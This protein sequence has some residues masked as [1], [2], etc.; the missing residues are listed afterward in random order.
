MTGFE[1]NTVVDSNT[2]FN[3]AK[4]YI[5]T[6]PAFKVDTINQILQAYAA[7]NRIIR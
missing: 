7:R 3:D 2:K 1:S 6:Q 5:V 4:T